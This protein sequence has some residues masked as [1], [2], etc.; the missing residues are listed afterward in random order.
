MLYPLS[1]LSNVPN[2]SRS[3]STLS[4]EASAPGLTGWSN[5]VAAAS[6]GC[7][8]GETKTGVFPDR[9]PDDVDIDGDV[10]SVD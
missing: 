1:K 6:D 4:E 7:E 3:N 9:V 2:G 5:K 10:S 8:L